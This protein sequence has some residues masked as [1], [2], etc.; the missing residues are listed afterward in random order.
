M[1]ISVIHDRRH[2][3]ALL[4]V[5]DGMKL[6]LIGKLPQKFFFSEK[7]VNDDGCSKRASIGLSL[8][9]VR[10]QVLERARVA[11]SIA[12]FRTACA[13]AISVASRSHC[14]SGPPVNFSPWMKLFLTRQIPLITSCATLARGA[15]FGGDHC[16]LPEAAEVG[17]RLKSSQSLLQRHA[18]KMWHPD[19][20]RNDPSPP[21][22]PPCP[23]ANSRCA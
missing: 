9:G 12:S 11:K 5:S 22:P 21:P 10:C 6:T 7:A 4:L 17:G 13:S 2:T 19:P 14:P 3:L 16:M 20:W 15:G 1:S 23:V 8:S 18:R